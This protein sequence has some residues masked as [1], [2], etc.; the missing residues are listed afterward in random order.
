V[1]FANEGRQHQLAI[2]WQ[3]EFDGVLQ[4]VGSRAMAPTQGQSSNDYVRECMRVMKRTYLPQNHPLYAVTMRTL[5]ADAINPIWGEL[6]PAVI[7]E[8]WNRMNVPKGELREIVQTDHRNGMKIH[9]FI[10]QQSFVRSPEYG[11]RP[12]RRVTGF[13]TPLDDRGQSINWNRV[14]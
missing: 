9:H 8:A 7:K 12:G 4:Q 3:E 13:R 11:F 14:P 2:A 5:P 1:A 10:G 6:K